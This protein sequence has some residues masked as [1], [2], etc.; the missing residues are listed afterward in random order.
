MTIEFEF[1]EYARN[2]IYR[3]KKSCPPNTLPY[4]LYVKCLTMGGIFKSVNA[5]SLHYLDE[6]SNQPKFNDEILGEV[7]ISIDGLPP[8]LIRVRLDFDGQ[9]F[10]LRRD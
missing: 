9:Y 2:E 1:S 5:Y 3:F 7:F 10:H 6:S 8:K 4:L